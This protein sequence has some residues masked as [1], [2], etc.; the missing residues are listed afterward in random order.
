MVGLVRGT[1]LVFCLLSTAALSSPFSL[2]SDPGSQL[3]SATLS[4]VVSLVRGTLLVFCHSSIAA[5]SSSPFSLQPNP[6]F[7]F[8]VCN[9]RFNCQPDVKISC[10]LFHSSTAALGWFPPSFCNTY[11]RERS[12]CDI[13]AMVS[14]DRATILMSCYFSTT[15]P[16]SLV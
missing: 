16:W 8:R 1:L 13:N 12:V 11:V 6:W 15:A 7:M 10:L 9:P 5:L 3:G 2:Q 14:Q 4:H